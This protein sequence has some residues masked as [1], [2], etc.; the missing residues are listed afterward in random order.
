MDI[1][2]YNLRIVI[3]DYKETDEEITNTFFS[4]R[5][6]AIRA[7]QKRHSKQPLNVSISA[8]WTAVYCA[9]I[10]EYGT[11]IGKRIYNLYKK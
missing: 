4:S 9:T 1:K 3:T 2:V 10:N 5:V 6:A 7:A 11:K 8:V